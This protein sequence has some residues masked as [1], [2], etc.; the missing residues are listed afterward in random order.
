MV[1]WRVLGPPLILAL[2]PFAYY[3]PATLGH[4]V[5]LE[6]DGFALHLP[7]RLLTAR[8]LEQ[9][10]WPLWNP[11]VLSGFPFLAGMQAALC[12]PTTWLFAVLPPAAAM[13]LQVMI[14]FSV[15]GL[16]MYAYMR[17]LGCAPLAA[18][19]ASLTFAYNGFMLQRAIGHLV[20]LLGVVW[21]PLVLWS[22]E[23][24]RQCVRAR[25]V[26][27]GAAALALAMFAGHPQMPA[28]ILFLA[29]AYIAFFTWAAPPVG[30]LRFAFW[31]GLTLAAGVLLSAVQLLP[32]YEL[33]QL[34]F[35]ASPTYETFVSFSLP[36]RQLPMLLSPFLLDG[37][38]GGAHWGVG[39]M[40]IALTGYVGLAALVLA[41]AVVRDA[42]RDI[43][44]RFWLAAAV[45]AL[46]LALGG[47]IPLARLTFHVPVYNT[48][49]AHAR[50]LVVFNCALAVLSGLALQRLPL[51]TLLPAAARRRRRHHR[52]R[53]DHRDHRPGHLGAAGGRGAHWGGAARLARVVVLAHQPR[54]RG[55][56]GDQHRAGRHRPGS[57]ANAARSPSRATRGA[58][59]RPSVFRQLV[60]AAV[61]ARW[62]GGPGGRRRGSGARH[63]PAA[64]R[65]PHR[66][67]IA[68]A[69]ALGLA[70]TDG[71]RLRIDPVE[72]LRRAGRGAGF[73][74]RGTDRG[75]TTYAGL[76][77]SAQRQV[78]GARSS[79][80]RQPRFGDRRHWVRSRTPR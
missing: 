68:S 11:A 1:R 79:A 53:G 80:A 67:T 20:L 77:R 43:H 38:A 45:V 28:Y 64:V 72:A 42:R 55:S 40:F 52:D 26:L 14:S 31:G 66:V 69:A 12:Y 70:D 32:T 56:R 49:R 24:L 2:A 63:R 39:T 35:R 71:E 10:Y 73:P 51:R 34:G 75:A 22:L 76:S 5:M 44:V 50:T 9:G 19:F 27:V 21:L 58:A 48:F 41:L 65:L 57:A 18:S 25:F 8:Y 33:G 23:R 30:R 29:A 3:W 78:H 54:A 47:A 6:S 59:R 37:R 13:N 60:R 17:A 46:L 4:V 7:F 16:A 15:A 36:P 62:R 61:S 74:R